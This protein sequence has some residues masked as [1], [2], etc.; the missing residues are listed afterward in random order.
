MAIT[1]K[2]NTK[3]RQGSRKLGT[4]MCCWHGYKMVKLALEKSLAVP[5]KLKHKSPYNSATPLLG[6]YM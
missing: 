4:L 1:K 3:Y 2:I 6:I 5:Q